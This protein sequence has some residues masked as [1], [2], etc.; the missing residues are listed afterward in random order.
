MAGRQRTGLEIT[1]IPNRNPSARRDR[2]RRAFTRTD[3][4]VAVAILSMLGALV[5]VRLT[6]AREKSRLTTCIANLSKVNGAV[7]AFAADNQQRLPAPVAGEP[8]NLWWWYKEQVKR[9]AGLSGE[10]SAND[11]VFACPSDRG[12]TDPIP[13]SRNARF[14]FSSYV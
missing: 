7:L 13:F 10:S 12:Y 6:A 3:L 5:V 8:R 1:M 2:R 4:L 9:Y 14:D 11:T